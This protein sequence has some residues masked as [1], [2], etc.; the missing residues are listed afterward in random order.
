MEV[1]EILSSRSKRRKFKEEIEIRS[2]AATMKKTPKD[3]GLGR[4]GK[5]IKE[6]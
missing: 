2:E 3:M 4:E 6:K 1:L 5:S